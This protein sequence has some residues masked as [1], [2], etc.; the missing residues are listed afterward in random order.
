MM[1]KTTFTYE[2]LCEAT[3]GFHHQNLL[4][5][6][7]FGKVY[8]GS[9]RH[10]DCAIKVL[11]VRR[12]LDIMKESILAICFPFFTRQDLSQISIVLGMFFFA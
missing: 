1:V 12:T 6:G 5:E 3:M 8:R 4:G 7:A 9:L 11:K 2:N 10:Q